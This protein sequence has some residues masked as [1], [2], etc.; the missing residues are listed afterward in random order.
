MKPK[1]LLIK[2]KILMTFVTQS[3][4]PLQNYTKVFHKNKDPVNTKLV[5]YNIVQLNLILLLAYLK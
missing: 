4:S 2:G 3:K 5:Y 1:L